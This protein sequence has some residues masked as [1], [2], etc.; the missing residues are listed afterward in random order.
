MYHFL[1]ICPFYIELAHIP[2]YYR[3]WPTTTMGMSSGAYELNHECGRSR[4]HQNENPYIISAI[5][6]GYKVH[7][8]TT[9]RTL[10]RIR[11]GCLPVHIGGQF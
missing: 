3:T 5:K 6:H 9:R 10:F 2:S 7:G 1:L 4:V 8:K 11:F